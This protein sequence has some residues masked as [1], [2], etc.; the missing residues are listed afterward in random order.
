MKM[1]KFPFIDY[2]NKRIQEY[3]LID[4]RDDCHIT[5]FKNHVFHA[6]NKEE[7]WIKFK[8][9]VIDNNLESEDINI[10]NK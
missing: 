3:K 6:S 2:K 8:E 9:I 5:K 1:K 10:Y 7:V 4:I